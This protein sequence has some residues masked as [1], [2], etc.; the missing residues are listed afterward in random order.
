M[1]PPTLSKG[2]IW[3]FVIRV[4]YGK[5]GR[6]NLAMEKPEKHYLGQAIQVNV[7]T[8]GMLIVYTPDRRRYSI[9]FSCAF[10]VVLFYF[11]FLEHKRE[12]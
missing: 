11:I 9:K 2:C 4:Q 7:L 12:G 1:A 8:D 3:W 6:G 5:K 10:V